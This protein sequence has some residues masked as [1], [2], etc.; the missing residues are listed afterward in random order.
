MVFSNRFELLGEITINKDYARCSK[1]PNYL[2]YKNGEIYNIIKKRMIKKSLTINNYEYCTLYS[3][4]NNKSIK[5]M[6]YVHRLIYLLFV[7]NIPDE[8]E[9]DHINHIRGDNNL[10][11]LRCISKAENRKNRR[12]NNNNYFENDKKHNDKYKI[13]YHNYYINK[14]NNNLIN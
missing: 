4:D 2:F 10:N 5:L 12:K 6:I 7:D 9:I 3:K 13:Y 11:N 14:K 1:Y 8:Y